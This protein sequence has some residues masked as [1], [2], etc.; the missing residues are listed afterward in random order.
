[1]D[2]LADRRRITIA[3]V[4]VLVAATA[5]AILV[6][7]I[8]LTYIHYYGA[9]RSPFTPILRTLGLWASALMPCVVSWMLALVALR[10]R[11]PRPRSRRLARQPGWLAISLGSVLVAIGAGI[12][13]PTLHFAGSMSFPD[14]WHLLFY[15]L[16]LVVG[17]GIAS[18]WMT[19]RC[20][21]RLRGPSDWIELLGRVVGCYWFVAAPLGF[22]MWWQ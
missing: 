9:P 4:M 6:A 12:I 5:P 1:M 18:S 3:D 10:F 14:I 2:A 13:A 11:H 8:V 16:P 7:R 15:I 22:W 21:G 19:A 20:L 17:P